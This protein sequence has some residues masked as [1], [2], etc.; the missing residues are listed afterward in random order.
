MR[1]TL[2]D[3][4]LYEENEMRPSIPAWCAAGILMLA[5]WS[6]TAL[7]AASQQ[8]VDAAI[9]SADTALAE[10]GKLGSVWAIWDPAVPGGE[11]APS[12]DDI[13]AVAKEKQKAGDLDEAMRLAKLVD[14]Y[15]TQG[16]AQ[17]QANEAAGIPDIK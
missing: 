3:S 7:A 6:C 17:A 11:D 13:L 10:A 12:L 2:I 8:D 4:Y 1:R 14:F 9:G 16:I 15:A 5:T